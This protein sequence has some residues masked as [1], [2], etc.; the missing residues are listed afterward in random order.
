MSHPG[1][2]GVAA[3][4][5]VR[6]G[7]VE[8]STRAG[9]RARSDPR[10]RSWVG[11]MAVIT[12]RGLR[13]QL[14]RAG[15]RSRAGF[16][17][18]ETSIAAAVLTIAVCGLSGSVVSAIALNRV[19]RETA[20]AEA[21]VRGVM[22]QVTGVQFAEAFARFNADA[23]DNPGLGLSPGATFD[24]AGLRGDGGAL[25]G[26]ITFPTIDDGGGPELREDTD[27]PA[28]GMPRDLNGDAIIDA[29]DHAGNYR[30]LPV[31][32]TVTWRGV[33]GLRT[34]TLES[35]LCAR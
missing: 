20:L 4:G 10:V 32:V 2:K 15:I 3:P 30:V 5:V 29:A 14:H 35:M 27:D 18:I 25:P 28:L 17:M 23:G 19:N 9:A 11:N 26:S 33:S 16:S 24:V 6:S 34:L 7:R 13:R 12:N 8:S 21:A 22:E 31:R 1:S